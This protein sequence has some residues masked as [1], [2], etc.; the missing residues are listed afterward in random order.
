MRRTDREVTD[1]HQMLEILG[2]CDCCRLGLTDQTGA[3]I[4]PMNFGYEEAGGKLFLYFHSA[5]EGKKLGLIQKQKHVSF[6]M[7]R[8]HKLVRGDIA[9]AYGFRFQS[10]MG[11]GRVEIL[12][13][14]EEKL[15]ALQVIMSHYTGKSQWDFGK[16]QLS[17]VSVLKLEVTS[18]SCKECSGL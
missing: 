14:E 13:A 2:A 6:E 7:D 17:A 18:W 1:Y 8:N 16:K 12:N 5:R 9:C 4:V 10:I 11:R 3:Y 15:H